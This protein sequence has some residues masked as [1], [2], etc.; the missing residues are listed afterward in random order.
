M[1]I[2]FLAAALL[3]ISSVYYFTSQEEV[4]SFDLGADTEF[5]KFISVHNKEYSTT[6]DMNAR[7]EIFNKNLETINYHNSLNKKYKLGVNQF[8]D[9]TDEEFAAMNKLKTGSSLHTQKPSF[10]SISEEKVLHQAEGLD[11]RKLGAVTRVKDQGR[12][13]S[14]WAFSTIAQFEGAYHIGYQQTHEFSEQHL[15]DCDRV[16]VGNLVNDG[17]NGG[18]MELALDYLAYHSAIYENDYPYISGTNGTEQNCMEDLVNGPNAYVDLD[19][20]SGEPRIYHTLL[21]TT[22]ELIHAIYQAPVSVA[23]QANSPI[24][25][26][27][28]E[29]IIDDKDLEEADKCFQGELNHGVTAVGFGYDRSNSSNTV[30]YI[31]IKNSWGSRWGDAGYANVAAHS[32]GITNDFVWSKVD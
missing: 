23:I 30:P 1:K 10:V 14:C 13:G 25:R 24:F 8:T 29:G 27:Y 18:F 22:E 2:L 3:A 19:D 4:N 15:V 9:L 21:G 32:C 16:K 11:W 7:R 6:K 26:S 5:L 31:T 20:E 28:R 12:C 17:C